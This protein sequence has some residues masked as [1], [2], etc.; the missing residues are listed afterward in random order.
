MKD[1]LKN[2]KVLII[3]GIVI[4]LL[5]VIIVLIS[6]VIGKNNKEEQMETL[7]QTLT[8]LGKQFYEEQYYVN[9][10][11]KEKLA[12][13]KDTGLNISITNLDVIVP[14]DS[15]TKETLKNRECDLDNTKIMFYPTSP[16]GLND[17][18]IKVE[19]ACE[20]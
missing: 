16:Y 19:L 17:Y 2:K 6:N 4:I 3:A 1:L 12:A 8:K 15:K 18:T 13:F 7:D 5:V 11:D 14:M 10:E 9:L 20:K